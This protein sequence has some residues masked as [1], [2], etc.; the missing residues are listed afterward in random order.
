M[1]L[2]TANDALPA[3]ALLLD[4]T[5]DVLAHGEELRHHAVVALHFPRWTD[6][7]AYSQAVLLR[8]RLRYRGQLLAHGDVVADMAPLLRRCG[9]DGAQ[10]RAD[11]RRETALRALGQIDAHYQDTL[12][13]RHDAPR[14]D[15][16][17]NARPNARPIPG[18]NPFPLPA[19]PVTGPARAGTPAQA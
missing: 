14:P 15:A 8:G 10:L 2:L 7:R 11:Q 18:P 13:E 19:E 1:Q 6:G 4:N 9:F 12:A 5:D 3:N 17:P 16:R